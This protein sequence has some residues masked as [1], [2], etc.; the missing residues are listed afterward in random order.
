MISFSGRWAAAAL[1]EQNGYSVMLDQAPEH[2]HG[3]NAVVHDYYSSAQ[4][5]L[6]GFGDITFRPAPN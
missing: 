2:P 6:A 4:V 1:P 3:V 5:S